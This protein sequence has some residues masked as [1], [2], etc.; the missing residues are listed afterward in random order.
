MSS[1]NIKLESEFVSVK[2]ENQDWVEP[3]DNEV[4]MDQSM[5]QSI[6]ETT[7]EVQ[8]DEKGPI[9]QENPNKDNNWDKKS[10]IVFVP[11]WSLF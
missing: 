9:I 4:S 10:V 11:S 8:M 2:S 6:D 3:R 5:N 1:V 7:R